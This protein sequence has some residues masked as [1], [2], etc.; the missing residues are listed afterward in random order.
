MKIMLIALISFFII[1]V[2]SLVSS[3]EKLTN[4]TE[5]IAQVIEDFFDFMAT[6]DIEKGKRT[7]LTNA[8]FVA[9][10]TENGA[11]RQITKEQHLQSVA[12]TPGILERI[13]DVKIEVNDSL[14][15]VWTEFDFYVQDNFS[16]CGTNLFSMIKT[17]EGW[18][19]AGAVFTIQTT[20]CPESPL[21][22]H[23]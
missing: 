17:T 13:W 12:A 3:Y 22:S 2:Q 6:Q 4:E 14:A 11:T 21:G 19:I 7:V 10:N 16:H 8:V 1:G 20:N 18:K 9:L 5:Q 23:P 15:T